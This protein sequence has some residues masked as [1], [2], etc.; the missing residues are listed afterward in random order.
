MK[1]SITSNVTIKVNSGRSRRRTTFISRYCFENYREWPSTLKEIQCWNRHTFRKEAK[2]FDKATDSE[3]KKQSSKHI[4]SN[5]GYSGNFDLISRM[6]HGKPLAYF[7]RKAKKVM[8]M[9]YLNQ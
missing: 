5:G 9:R 1:G 2:K 6:Y 4:R 8:M 7:V 3:R